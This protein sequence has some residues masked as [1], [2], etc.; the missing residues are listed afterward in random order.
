MKSLTVIYTK[1]WSW[2]EP[3]EIQYARNI[4]IE[5][6]GETRHWLWNLEHCKLLYTKKA[7]THVANFVPMDVSLCKTKIVSPRLPSPSHFPSPHD[8]YPS[9][10]HQK[11]EQTAWRLWGPAMQLSR[12]ET[13]ARGTRIVCWT[14]LAA[15]KCSQH[16]MKN[17]QKCGHTTAWLHLYKNIMVRMWC[18]AHTEVT[19]CNWTHVAYRG[20]HKTDVATCTGL[21]L[22]I[23]VWCC[24]MQHTQVDVAYCRHWHKVA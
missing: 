18:V 22:C 3:S 12:L 10:L 5:G 6:L 1:I 13:E 4:F 11:S 15:G 17:T 23:V 19:C 2:N 7:K 8:D 24:M 20:V 14:L 9:R 16:H 21:M